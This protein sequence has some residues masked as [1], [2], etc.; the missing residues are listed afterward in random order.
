MRLAALE[1]WEK[2]GLKTPPNDLN[3]ENIP[4]FLEGR[5]TFSDELNAFGRATDSTDDT[6]VWR[7]IDGLESAFW[8]WYDAYRGRPTEGA[9]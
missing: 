1:G 4:R 6:D 5:A 2:L 9:V 3:R 7:A 8:G